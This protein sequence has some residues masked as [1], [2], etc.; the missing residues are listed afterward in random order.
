MVYPA[1]WCNTTREHDFPILKLL[2]ILLD[3]NHGGFVN[4][5]D[6]VRSVRV[7]IKMSSFGRKRRG[8]KP[9]FLGVS[10]F[11][12]LLF[13]FLLLD[14]VLRLLGLR[15]FWDFG[16]FGMFRRMRSLFR[17]RSRV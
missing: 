14:P 4:D 8:L 2:E 12:L 9:S 6:Q 16:G 1:E 5:M 13:L 7:S 15:G 3:W 11:L 10:S 17:E